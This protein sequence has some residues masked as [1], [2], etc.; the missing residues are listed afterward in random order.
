[1]PTHRTGCPTVP[2]LLAAPIPEGVEDWQAAYTT[3]ASISMQAVRQADVRLG[4][5]VMVMMLN[6]PEVIQ[7]FHALWRIGAVAVP[8]TA[9]QRPD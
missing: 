1:M 5:R 6:C 7:A 4:D 3:L 8:V 2:D 9:D